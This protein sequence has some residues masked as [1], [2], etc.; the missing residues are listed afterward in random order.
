MEEERTARTLWLGSSV[1]KA[2]SRY[3]EETLN[4]GEFKMKVESY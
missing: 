3:K 2:N 4:G 1:K